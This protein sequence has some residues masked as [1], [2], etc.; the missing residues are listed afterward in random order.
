MLVS[1]LTRLSL[2]I[3]FYFKLRLSFLPAMFICTLSSGFSATALDKEY[4][5]TYFLAT[6]MGS[7]FG[8]FSYLAEHFFS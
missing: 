4:V 3:L 5:C 1:L 6:S 2:F 8:G 7:F